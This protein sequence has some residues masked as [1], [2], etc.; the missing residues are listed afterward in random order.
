VLYL[1]RE[2]VGWGPAEAVLTPANQLRARAMAE[3]WD[4]EAE[5]CSRGAA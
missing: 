4:P 3:G 5:A 2:A 1:A